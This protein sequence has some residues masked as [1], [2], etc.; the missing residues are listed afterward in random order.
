MKQMSKIQ[1]PPSKSTQDQ[2]VD[3][4]I[5]LVL[6][7]FFVWLVG[8]LIDFCFIPLEAVDHDLAKQREEE[9]MEKRVARREARMAKFEQDESDPMH[10]FQLRFITN[11]EEYRKDPDNDRYLSWYKQWQE[12]KIIDTYLRWAPPVVEE[13]ESICK[14]FLAYLNIQINLHKKESFLRKS[15]FLS[16]IRSCYPEFT[17]SFKG[18]KQDVAAYAAELGEEALT[19]E[20]TEELAAYG[21]HEQVAKFIAESPN[22]KK[23]M[24]NIDYVKE[25]NDSCNHILAVYLLKNGIKLRTLKAEQAA[26]VITTLSLPP[27]FATALINKEITED[28]LVEIKESYD[29]MKDWVGL[30]MYRKRE[31]GEYLCDEIAKELI[32]KHRGNNFAKKVSTV[33]SKK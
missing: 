6:V 14:A 15:L 4:I 31:N 27:A 20:I 26:Y 22:P 8:K 18:L 33:C 3:N 29:S 13:D 19:K 12:G 2:F 25:V 16:N 21:L 10:Q 23:Y 5:F 17:P 32:A 7:G 9:D 30:E 24:E 28:D 1:S 11:N